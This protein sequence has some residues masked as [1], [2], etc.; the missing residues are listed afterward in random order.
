MSQSIMK[1]RLS[2]EVI[3]SPFMAEK[4]ALQR[5]ISTSYTLGLTER[6]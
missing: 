3:E 5:S 4:L 6:P 1:Y 2:R